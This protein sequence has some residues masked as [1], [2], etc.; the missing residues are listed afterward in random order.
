MRFKTNFGWRY[1]SLTKLESGIKWQ[2]FN[3]EIDDVLRLYP[4]IITNKINY[5]KNSYSKWY[6]LATTQ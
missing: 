5:F 3:T 1:K 6:L 2:F 4:G